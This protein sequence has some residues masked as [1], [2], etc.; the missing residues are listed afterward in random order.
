MT[1]FDTGVTATEGINTPPLLLIRRILFILLL[2]LHSFK[3][4]NVPVGYH[5]KEHLPF[6]VFFVYDIE[7][8]SGKMS[9]PTDTLYS[10]IATIR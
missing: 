8:T 6:C 2:L 1:S 5:F 9:L 10:N 7:K 3:L 4:T